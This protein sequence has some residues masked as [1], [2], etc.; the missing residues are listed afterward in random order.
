MKDEEKVNPKLEKEKQTDTLG[1]YIR[2]KK[3]VVLPITVLPLT[4]PETGTLTN[5]QM[6]ENIG[7]GEYYMLTGRTGFLSF[8]DKNGSFCQVTIEPTAIAQLKAIEEL[9]TLEKQA[10]IIELLEKM[11]FVIK[12]SRFQGGFKGAILW[13]AKKYAEKQKQGQEQEKGFDF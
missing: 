11:G 6:M 3:T 5:Q 13:G 8:I 1:E 2:Q 4:T 9:T 12:N 10:E 7:H